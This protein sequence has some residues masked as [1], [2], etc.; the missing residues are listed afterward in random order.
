MARLSIAVLGVG[1][2]AMA[3]SGC[4]S[5][6]RSMS[7][8]PTDAS[9]EVA[10]AAEKSQGAKAV[11]PPAPPPKNET[12]AVRPNRGGE[13][14]GADQRPGA[15]AAVRP[16]PR[17]L[18]MIRPVTPIGGDSGP[19]AAGG[20]TIASGAGVPVPK[21]DATKLD[22]ALA[23]LKPGNLAYTTPPNM[24]MADTA[25]IVARIGTDE[26]SAAA[27]AAG[28]ATDA[29]TQVTTVATSTT[30]K[31][32]MTLTSG[33]F[34]ITALSSEEQ[35]VAGSVPTTWAWDIQ[36]KHSGTLRLHLAATI[37]LNGMAKDFTTVD[38][39]IAVKVDPADMVGDFVR[40]NWQWL[41]ATLTA[42]IGGAWKFFSARKRGAA[43]V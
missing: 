26:V 19:I 38:R 42:L 27:L 28:M 10:P 36:P 32:K 1:A 24:K 8:P 43:A 16:V 39:E 37:E 34:T 15:S 17:P 29:G 33:D 22:D 14:V 20:E 30:P 13:A 35:M 3:L 4:S 6:P 21:D 11:M 18:Q 5:A 40:G 2:L 12:A 9:T 41:I 25:H 31:M 23:H 7:T